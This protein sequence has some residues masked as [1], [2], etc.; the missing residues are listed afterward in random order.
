[1]NI[2]S[3]EVNRDVARDNTAAAPN[4]CK[5]NT[6]LPTYNRAYA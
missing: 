5:Y 4:K 3:V 1:M 6:Y 2:I